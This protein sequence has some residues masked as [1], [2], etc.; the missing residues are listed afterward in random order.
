MRKQQGFTIIELVVVIVIL[1]ILAAIAAPKF[2]NLQGDARRTVIQGVEGAL[3]GAASIVHAKALIAGGDPATVTADG[4]TY[5][6]SKR[7]PAATSITTASTGSIVSLNPASDFTL[8]TSGTPVNAVEVRHARAA[9]PANCYVRYTEPA[10]LG[11]EPVFATDF[12]GC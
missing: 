10:T 4:N 2:L 5:A 7:Y 1:G 8:V 3:R 6:V 9:T 12:T 11:A